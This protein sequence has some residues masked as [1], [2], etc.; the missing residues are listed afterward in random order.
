MLAQDVPAHWLIQRNLDVSAAMCQRLSHEALSTY[1][2]GRHAGW[3]SF[4]GFPETLFDANAKA[5]ADAPTYYTLGLWGEE[6]RL[7][8]RIQC[9]NGDFWEMEHCNQ[10]RSARLRIVSSGYVSD[11]SWGMWAIAGFAINVNSLIGNPT[12]IDCDNIPY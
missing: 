4:Q 9:G 5:F 2:R 7:S 3:Y 1:L 11:L 12:Y 6:P 10:K 8:I